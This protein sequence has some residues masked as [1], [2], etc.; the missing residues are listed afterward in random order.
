[1]PD[2]STAP[3]RK[4]TAATLGGAVTGVVFGVAEW[5]GAP[6][7]PTLLVAGITTLAAFAAGY[8]TSD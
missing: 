4:I 1:M 7:P 6:D 3:T 8:V 2:N 5:L